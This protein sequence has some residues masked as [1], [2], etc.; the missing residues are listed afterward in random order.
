MKQNEFFRGIFGL[1][2]IGVIVA[3]VTQTDL[4]DQ[5]TAPEPTPAS[6]PQER[7]QQIVRGEIGP[8]RGIT[9]VQVNTNALLIRYE[10]VDS[11]IGDLVSYTGREMVDI[12]CALRAEFP[13]RRYRLIATVPLVDSFGNESVGD[14]VDAILNADTTAAINCANADTVR[15]AGVADSWDVHPA[16]E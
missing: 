13:G 3:V 9:Q 12:T 7:V 10:M 6:D 11:L 4:I 8:N 1:V 15:M 14:G 5:L 2:I 16:L